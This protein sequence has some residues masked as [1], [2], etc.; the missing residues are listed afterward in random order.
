MAGGIVCPVAALPWGHPGKS[1]RLP[2]YKWQRSIFCWLHSSA[3]MSLTPH[4]ISGPRR[5][6]LQKGQD[7]QCHHQDPDLDLERPSRQ[8]ADQRKVPVFGHCEG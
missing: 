3:V 5:R 2:G 1:A 8:D 7:S 6:G 4:G